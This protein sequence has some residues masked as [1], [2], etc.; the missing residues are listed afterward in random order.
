[1][2]GRFRLG[3]A[4][5]CRLARGSR[6]VVVREADMLARL[7]TPMG[8][9]VALALAACAPQKA[10]EIA[11]A[12]AIENVTLIPMDREAIVAGQTVRVVDGKIQSVTPA[13][14]KGA[15][16]ERTVDGSGKFLAPG[17]NDMHM[18]VES[19]MFASVFGMP[20]SA[21]PFE[22]LLYVYLSNGVTGVRVM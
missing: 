6:G 15:T 17:L 12:L 8:A 18:H 19:E 4:Y 22:D 9:A 7:A 13:A 10:P 1:M 20:A 21:L 5:R 2:R 3:L 11:C 14:E 16:C